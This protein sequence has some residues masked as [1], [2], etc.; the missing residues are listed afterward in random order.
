ML[1]STNSDIFIRKWLSVGQNEIDVIRKWK[2]EHKSRLWP[3]TELLWSA[4][5]NP[6]HHILYARTLVD[7]QLSDFSFIIICWWMCL[8]YKAADL[9]KADTNFTKPHKLKGLSD[10][11][12]VNRTGDSNV[13]SLF[14]WL[15]AKPQSLAVLSVLAF[16]SCQLIVNSWPTVDAEL[17]HF[18]HKLGGW[19]CLCL[20]SYQLR[21]SCSHRILKGGDEECKL[22]KIN[23]LGNL[24]FKWALQLLQQSWDCSLALGWC[25]FC[26]WPWWV[27]LWLAHILS[28]EHVIF[29]YKYKTRFQLHF[30]SYWCYIDGENVSWFSLVISSRLLTV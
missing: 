8:A 23:C 6:D 25:L 13:Y 11:V 17:I 12:H 4:F 16:M 22:L 28:S 14:G 19:K 24:L 18:V 9:H 7:V 1:S 30:E 15:F 2:S 21:C 29:F 10:P 3:L 5:W 20:L 27:A 26:Q